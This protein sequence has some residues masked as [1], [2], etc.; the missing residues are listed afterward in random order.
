VL[1][2]KDLDAIVTALA[3]AV[4]RIH[5]VAP[6]SARARPAAEIGA[7]AIRAGVLAEVHGSLAAALSRARSLAGEGGLVCVAGS[8]YL[9][10][11]ARVG[12]AREDGGGRS[13]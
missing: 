12:L 13:M 5:A 8:L 10:G 6:A 1:A 9:V 4:R 2:D 3:P 7:A 11:E